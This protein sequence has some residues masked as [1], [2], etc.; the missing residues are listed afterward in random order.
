MLK[1][2][3]DPI[4]AHPL[5][6]G[7]RFPMVKYELIPAQLLREGVVNPDSFFKPEEIAEQIILQT[8]GKDYWMQLRD[9]TL[10]A[11]EQRRI[12]FPLTGLLVERERRIAQGTIDGCRFAFK[13]YM[14]LKNLHSCHLTIILQIC[15]NK[16][17]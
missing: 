17:G 1:I 11:K 14:L 3:F 8:H 5:P 15:C 4:Y 16:W 10:P 13:L 9:L 7:H 2:A 6:H 12:G